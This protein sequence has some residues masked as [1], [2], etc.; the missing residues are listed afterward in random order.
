ME[1]TICHHSRL[2]AQNLL[3]F[4]ALRNGQFFA[5]YKY[6]NLH[7]SM[8]GKFFGFGDL[9]DDDIAR[10][11]R[12]MLADDVFEGYNENHFSD[13]FRQTPHAMIRITRE[14]VTYPV[15]DARDTDHKKRERRMRDMMKEA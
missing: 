4:F 13:Q 7:W 5:N 6:K 10:I 1:V 9:R 3:T 15:A 12:D 8:N 11:R 2:D 14:T